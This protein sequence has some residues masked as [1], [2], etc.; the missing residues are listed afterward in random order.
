MQNN[1]CI[2]YRFVWESV[3][4]IVE[5]RWQDKFSEQLGDAPEIVSYFLDKPFSLQSRILN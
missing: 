3:S 4:N 5:Q 1:I 2:R